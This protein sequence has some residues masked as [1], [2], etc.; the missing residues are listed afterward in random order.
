MK[1]ILLTDEKKAVAEKL[2]ELF[3]K[4]NYEVILSEWNGISVSVIKAKE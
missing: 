1:L 4:E 3:R 2:E